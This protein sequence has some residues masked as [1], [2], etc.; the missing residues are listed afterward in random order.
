MDL[1]W[2]GS[3][4]LWLSIHHWI[5]SQRSAYLANTFSER[6]ICL[7]LLYIKVCIRD[8]NSVL[9]G[10]L[11][12]KRYMKGKNANGNT[13]LTALGTDICKSSNKLK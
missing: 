3:S 10:T 9:Q 5:L 8:E 4:E 1:A 7:T 13:K 2:P 12:T 11:H 6:N